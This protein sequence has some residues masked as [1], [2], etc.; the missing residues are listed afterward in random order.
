VCSGGEI[1]FEVIGIPERRRWRVVYFAALALVLAIA[2]WAA[3]ETGLL[4]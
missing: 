1:A 2:I 3:L 4:F